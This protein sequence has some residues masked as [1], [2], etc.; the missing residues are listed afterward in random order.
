[1]ESMK[2]SRGILRKSLQIDATSMRIQTGSLQKP[3]KI[4][5]ILRGTLRK[6]MKIID[7]LKEYLNKTYENQSESLRDTLRNPKGNR[8]SIIMLIASQLRWS[9]IFLQTI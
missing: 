8:L 2:L 9:Q 6:S 4:N 5:E 7:N 3:T 1:M